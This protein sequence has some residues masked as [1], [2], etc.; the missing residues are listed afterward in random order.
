M[1]SLLDLHDI[2]GNVVRAYGPAGFPK[3][4]YFVMRVLDGAGGRRFLGEL[5]QFITTSAGWPSG[6][7]PAVATNIAF[8]FE[9]LRAVGVPQAS[10][11]GFPEEFAVGMRA[12]K[13]I[14]GDD[15]ASAPDHWDPVWL[16]DG[17]HLLLTVN[18]RDEEAV[19]ARYQQ[20]LALAGKDLEVLR[21]HRCGSA[22]DAPYQSASVLYDDKGEATPKE[23]FGYTDGISNPYFKGTTAHPATVI[24]GGKR[25]GKDPRTMEGWA[26]IETGEFLLGHKDE[27]EEYPMAPV[28]NLLS[29]NGTFLVYR[30]L[31]ENVKSFDDY[32]EHVGAE[33]PQGKE[34]LAAK[35][36]GRWRT[37]APLTTF[38]TQ[39][40][41]DQ[42][43]VEWRAAK[44]AISDA[45]NPQAREK[46][47]QRFS[48][49][50]LSF[51]A[52]DYNQDI[53]GGKCPVG[54]HL[55]RANPRGALEFGNTEAFK[56]PGA[57]TNRRRLLR[58]GLPYG[59][60]RG[61]RDNRGD[62][63]I[64]FMAVGSSIQRQFEFV[65]QQ[66]LN[67]G[68][69]FHLG[70]EKDPLLGN[71]ALDERGKATGR[72]TV[73]GADDSE[74]PPFFCSKLPRFVETRGGEY[75]FVPSL[76]ALGMLADGSIDPT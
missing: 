75:F 28:P 49:L 44:K 72:M 34:A 76:T 23:H 66:W 10:L 64:I 56:T 43:A 58:R 68:N 19:E 50:N 54:A 73:P 32:L 15:G 71:H 57:L 17:V 9:G 22:M 18:G 14:L 74:D 31:H 67:Y 13:D 63:G 36:A 20:I 65:Q 70:N 4:R 42:F 12:R 69:D 59:D 46:A 47:K 11:Q 5:Q 29:R 48:E 1:S 55:R 35:M 40:E 53:P 60:S 30:K 52:F 38:P 21:G 41:A 37:G 26:P 7:P 2:Q 3:A 6:K 62:H 51:V 61:K 45:P 8:T 27:A 33:Y 25:T 24:G 16:R 39:E